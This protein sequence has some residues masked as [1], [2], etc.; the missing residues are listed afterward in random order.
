MSHLKTRRR[1]LKQLMATGTLAPLTM[2]GMTNLAWANGQSKLKVVFAVIPDGFG[3]DS[4]GG[5]SDGIWFPKV[6]NLSHGTDTTNFQLNEISR[7]LGSHA[8]NALFLRGLLLSSGTGG[9]NAWKYVL[10]DS[11]G[12]KTSIDLL[13]GDALRG[14][15]ATLKRIYSGPHSTVGANWN[16][17]YQ[18][19]SMIVPEINPYNLFN[20]VHAGFEGMSSNVQSSNQA[21]GAHLFDPV[22]EQLSQLR[23]KLGTGERAK[24]DTHLDAME[25]AVIDL[26]DTV[27]GA[28]CNPSIA[29]PQANMAVTSASHRDPVT[30]AH[31][32]VIASGLSC[33]ASRVA[34]F[35]IG[36]SA[37]PVAITSVSSSRNPHDCAHRYG[38][39]AEWRDSRA[40]YIHQTKYLL[41]QLAAYPD[42][43]VAGDSLLDHTLVVLTSE[44]ADGA[45]EHMQDVPVTLIGGASGLL[46][47]GN[48][49]GRFL[50]LQAQGDRSHWRL[51]T[52]TDMQRVWTT[53]AR[54]AGTSTPY[55]GNT[56]TLNNLFT[57][58]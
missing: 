12:S 58:V 56:S 7:H 32:K 9:H 8:N 51:G 1:F 27:P 31:A 38:S 3:V 24:L 50:N 28:E 14:S 10:R 37:D 41:D 48:G 6:G 40:W 13:L 23:A 47:N 44:M 30:R 21:S 5:Y 19:N 42:P 49:A 18:N 53:I 25:Q 15:N 43:D 46:K 34:T 55:G 20:Q 52:A 4:F 2:A 45:P 36:R 17:S 26:N 22:S 29:Q 35:Q 33:G 16:I 11:A 39:V 57:N 54:A